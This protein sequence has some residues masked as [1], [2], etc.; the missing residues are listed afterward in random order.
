MPAPDFH[1][2]NV[3]VYAYDGSQP[4]K[5]R[6]AQDLLRK[7]V[8]GEIVTSIQVLAEFAATL[9]HTGSPAADAEDGLHFYDG[10]IVVA[11]ERDGSAR[12]WP[13]NM[14]ARQNTSVSLLRTRLATLAHAGE[15][16]RA[17]TNSTRLVNCTPRLCEIALLP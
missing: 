5:Q 15:Q 17:F 8:A 7:A 6:V 3:L 11:A 1:D 10:M 16:G 12:I 2:T 4:G 14:N 13:A 9:L